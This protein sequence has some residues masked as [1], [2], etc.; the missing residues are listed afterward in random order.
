MGYDGALRNTASNR[1]GGVLAKW[2]LIAAFGVGC[3]GRA[4]ELGE[5]GVGGAGSAGGNGTGDGTLAGGRGGQESEV[6]LTIQGSAFALAADAERLYWIESKD[7]TT[8][9]MSCA[10][11]SCASSLVEYGQAANVVG[12]RLA[13][14][15]GR[16]YWL[17]LARGLPTSFSLVT[18]SVTGCEGAPRRLAEDIWD[19]A[20]DDDAVYYLKENTDAET[21]DRAPEIVRLPHDGD[22]GR[23]TLVAKVSPDSRSLVVHGFAAYWAQQTA[24]ALGSIQ[25]APKLGGE[26]ETV[27]EQQT[28]PTSL[29]SD[30]HAIYWGNQ[31]LAGWI[32]SIPPGGDEPEQFAYTRIYYPVRLPYSVVA[33]GEH[34]YWVQESAQGT[35]DLVRFAPW[36]P[37]EP[38]LVL[39]DVARPVPLGVAEFHGFSAVATDAQAVYALK[40]RTEERGGESELE[41]T[42]IHRVAR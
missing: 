23:A 41:F 13:V 16:V 5:G 33:D 36:T 8:R 12:L 4:L 40:V 18:C 38:A 28:N 34:L 22:P 42:D 3:R 2:A 9:A 19:I 37:T 25:R 11:R 15:A 24:G 1:G 30:G 35:Q 14:A 17:E 31:S 21:L 32:A 39:P 27:I 10:K 29:V 26:P 6:V 20:V 7:E